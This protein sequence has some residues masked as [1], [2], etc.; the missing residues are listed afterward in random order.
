[1]KAP[2]ALGSS[3]RQ[4]RSSG[5]LWTIRKVALT[6]HCRELYQPLKLRT[7]PSPF[8]PESL[9][10]PYLFLQDFEQ[11]VRCVVCQ[12]GAELASIVLD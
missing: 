1:M 12:D 10:F 2:F 6:G 4:G 8:S 11:L 5:R 9:S 3:I 7:N